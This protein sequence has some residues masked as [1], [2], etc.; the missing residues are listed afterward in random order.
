MTSYGAPKLTHVPPNVGFV[1]VIAGGTVALVA[2]VMNVPVVTVI[3]AF[4]V[5][6]MSLEPELTARVYIVDHLWVESPLVFE[7]SAEGVTLPA[8]VLFCDVSI[9]SAVVPFVLSN[10]LVARES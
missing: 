3:L 1:H 10:K 5:S 8:K 2:A 9:V 6:V 4:G 7:L